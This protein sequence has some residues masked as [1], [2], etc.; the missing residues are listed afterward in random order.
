[1]IQFARTVVDDI[2]DLWKIM[3]NINGF[4]S[5]ETVI[6]TEEEFG[7]WLKE[8]A[9]DPLTCLDDG[10]VIGCGYLDA[11]Y[12]GYYGS[13]NIFKIPRHKSLR[14]LVEAFKG[15]LSYWMVTHDFEKIVGVIR[16]D[17]RA[18]RLLSGLLG[19]KVDGVLRHHKQVN[20]IWTDYLL[21]SILR[22]EL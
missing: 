1:M 17:N 13:A 14:E 4:F 8:N 2:P 20:G 5:D 3:S 21:T 9:Q 18:C 10:V 7:N 15:V 6:Q 22:S 12:P 19:F 11:V 16:N